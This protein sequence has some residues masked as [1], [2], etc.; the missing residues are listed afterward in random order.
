MHAS[1]L[2]PP[3][4]EPV[5]VAA[6]KQAARLDGAHWDAIV[7]PAIASARQVAEHLTGR[8]LMT[9]T[10][11]LELADWPAASDVLRIYRPTAVA[12]TYWDGAAWVAL[13]GAA[14]AWALRDPGFVVA[15]VLGTDW[16]TLGDVPVGY[17][18]RIH[19]TAGAADAAGVPAVAVDFIK[20][21]VA[22]MVKDPTLSVDDALGSARWLPRLLDPIRVYR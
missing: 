6:A 15:P 10:W 20:A 22:V 8:C 14:F 7:A 1:L 4:A 13:D 17:R 12:V 5:S 21:L 19:A 2:T 9:Q 3:T 11:R 16:P 18:V